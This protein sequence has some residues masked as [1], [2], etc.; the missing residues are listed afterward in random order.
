MPTVQ[1][2]TARLDRLEARQRQANSAGVVPHGATLPTLTPEE[3]RGVIRVL[4]LIGVFVTMGR[5]DPLW[6]MRVELFG[7]GDELEEEA[8]SNDDE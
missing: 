2:L 7:Q 4:V 6:H 8:T 5:D 1:A 3:A